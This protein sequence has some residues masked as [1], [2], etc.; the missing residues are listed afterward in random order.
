MWNGLGE[1]LKHVRQ[2]GSTTAPV[3]VRALA[4]D[5]HSSLKRR[6]RHCSPP[7]IGFWY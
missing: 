3:A 1:K 2:S 5:S 6:W 7:R 4:E